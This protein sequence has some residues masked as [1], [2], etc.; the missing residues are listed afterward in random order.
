MRPSDTRATLLS[1]LLLAATT[2]AGCLSGDDAA[3]VATASEDGATDAS[4]PAADATRPAPV[5]SPPAGSAVLEQQTFEGH[6]TYVV[7]GAYDANDPA[8]FPVTFPA[9][10]GSVLLEMEWTPSL[11]TNSELSLM[12]HGK[13]AASSDGM[14]ADTDGSSPLRLVLTP[15]EA[16]DGEYDV[17]AYVPMSKV[18]TTVILD[19]DFTIHATVFSGGVPDGFTAAGA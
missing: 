12:L 6:F 4:P 19:Q 5:E 3:H 17:V 9:G 7:A 11:A 10:Y 1:L 8:F 16:P 2:L 13:G 14:V 18:M 15:A